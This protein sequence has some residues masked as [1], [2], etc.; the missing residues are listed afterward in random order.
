MKALAFQYPALGWREVGASALLALLCLALVGAP[1]ASAA[2]GPQMVKNI[3]TSGS[4]NPYALTD[5]DGVLMFAAKGGGR[6]YELWRSDGTAVGTRRVKDINPG[7]A[8]SGPDFLTAINGTL[9]F[10]AND[11]VH[12]NELWISDGTNAGTRL[13]KDINPGVADSYPHSFVLYD[14]K[15]YFAARDSADGFELWRTDGTTAGTQRVKDLTGSVGQL[16]AFAGRL[17]FSL[18]VGT[19]NPTDSLYVSNGTAVG[20]RPFKN[21]L[22]N[23]ITGGGDGTQGIGWLTVIG[24]RMV[25][26]R[27]ENELWRTDGSAA[28]TRRIA[29]L[30]TWA[31]TRVGSAAFFASGEQLWR[32][33]GTSAGTDFVADFTNSGAHLLTELNGEAFFFAFGEP[34]TSDGTPVGTEAVGTQVQADT[35]VAVLDG[36]AYFG[37][38]ADEDFAAAQGASASFVPA[39]L[40]TVWRSDGTADGTYSVG[41]PES[42]IGELVVAGGTIYFT[43]SADGYGTELWRYVP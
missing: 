20:T 6:G 7:S 4:S 14:G 12:G 5:V 42:H 24:S 13:V 1:T 37:G 16:T 41:G 19:V 33:D 9:Y 22:G 10:G 28:T 26:T 8:G 2:T 18:S 25:F 43:A 23:N 11:G 21:R 29:T 39:P 34:W 31:L 3:N 30:A 27:N 17:F 15:V 32:T 35:D 36:V 38:W 40:L